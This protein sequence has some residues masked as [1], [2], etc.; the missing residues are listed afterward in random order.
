MSCKFGKEKK[1]QDC[2][3][4]GV[5][6]QIRT[7]RPRGPFLPKC[8]LVGKSHTTPALTGVTSSSPT[9]RVK[10]PD[11]LWPT[12][13]SSLP[14]GNTLHTLQLRSWKCTYSIALVFIFFSMLLSLLAG[15][16]YRMYIKS[17]N[18]NPEM[19]HILLS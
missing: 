16:Y 13:I 12:Q 2:S 17:T 7:R 19:L 18:K 8:P 1:P 11:L 10:A 5:G 9:I 15:Q 6:G 14:S 4:G 3:C